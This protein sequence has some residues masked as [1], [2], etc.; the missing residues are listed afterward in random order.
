M[1]R[2]KNKELKTK[3]INL[4]R[5]ALS[6][7][8][9]LCL[10]I[11][12]A[13]S[14]NA[15]DSL[16]LSLD[17]AIEIS[18]QNNKRELTRTIENYKQSNASYQESKATYKPKLDFSYNYEYSSYYSSTLNKFHEGGLA[19]DYSLISPLG[20]DIKISSGYM[21]SRSSGKMNY[22][23]SASISLTQPLS[24]AEIDYNR[25][26]FRRFD[27]S[28]KYG[29][30]SYKNAVE[31]YIINVMNSYISLLKLQRSLGRS[32]ASLARSQRMLAIAKIKAKGGEIAEDEVMNLDVEVV[33]KEDEINVSENSYRN[34]KIEFLRLLGLEKQGQ[35]L[36][37]DGNLEM[38]PF[39]L[40]IEEC[41]G[42][43][44]NKRQELKLSDESLNF[45]NLSYR[46]AKSK[47]KPFVTLDYWHSFSD[48]SASPW[49]K[50]EDLQKRDWSFKASLSFPI[51]DGG[52]YKANLLRAGSNL[53][54]ETI[55][56]DEL[57]YNIKREVEEI[58]TEQQ[59]NE[60]R[61]ES[62]ERN[63]K[64]AEKALQI[65]GKK[66]KLGLISQDEINRTE[67]RLITAQSSLDDARFNHVLLNARLMKSMADFESLY[68]WREI[69]DRR[70]CD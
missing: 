37:L 42:R 7:L 55:A 41:I 61:L 45:T 34:R 62:L 54:I 4:Y 40:S 46:L 47:N 31:N 36:K 13:N 1:K 70:S 48:Q 29:E 27:L 30:L 33:I 56:F 66:F 16:K 59:M 6:V 11:F 60:K 52:V 65:G 23:P 67:E 44:L 10:F 26:I 17:N 5:S 3:Y 49:I 51:I 68:N 9:A 24:F 15:A 57:K 18:L 25:S 39:K 14:L 8:F 32:R 43:A 64:V 35:D 63:I 22:C 12:T 38:I 19:L 69:L 53:K 50:R 28:K 2:I 20:G 21:A 58:Y